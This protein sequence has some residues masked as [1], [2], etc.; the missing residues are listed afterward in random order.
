MVAL[1][2]LLTYFLA[3]QAPVPSP[4]LRGLP[5]VAAAAPIL[6]EDNTGNRAT[7]R[8]GQTITNFITGNTE[9]YGRAHETGISTQYLAAWNY[10][11]GVVYLDG[12]TASFI[13]N[14]AFQ[15]TYQFRLLMRFDGLD[16]YIPPGMQI[17]QAQLTFTATNWQQEA[18]LEV[19]FMTKH[20]NY[21]T[22]DPRKYRDTGWAFS[23]WS[24][25]QS[26]AWSTP[27]GWGDCDPRYFTTVK[28]AGNGDSVHSISLPPELVTEWLSSSGA[29]NHGVFFRAKSGGASIMCSALS[30][31]NKCPALGIIYSIQ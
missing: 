26:L 9:L 8:N 24:G 28:V 13:V 20:W 27:G 17:L 16:N 22:E 18:E 23:S 25:A 15:S 31:A 5:V 7:F 21:A 2:S 1:S 29:T 12:S 3:P 19:C 4:Q 11:N 6:A 14:E 30:A 10:N